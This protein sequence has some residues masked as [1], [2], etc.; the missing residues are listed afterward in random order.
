M[1]CI[2]S[3]RWSALVCLLAVLTGRALAQGVDIDQ[4]FPSFKI[5]DDILAKNPKNAVA[6]R[7]RGTAYYHQKDF[8]NAI[9][10]FTQ[11]I[12]LNPKDTLAYTGRGV[13]HFKNGN[14]GDALDDLKHAVRLNPNSASIYRHLID[15]CF[16]NEDW[17]NVISNATQLIRVN[18]SESAWACETRGEAWQ[19]KSNFDRAI[20]EFDAAIRLNPNWDAP[21]RERASILEKKGDFDGVLADLNELVRL[22]PHNDQNYY[23]RSHIYREKSDWDGIIANWTEAIANNPT[24]T[25]YLYTRARAYQNHNKDFAKAIA[26]YNKIVELEPN[27]PRHYMARGFAYERENLFEMAITNYSE[28]IQLNPTNSDGY[29]GR[30]GAYFHD[31]QY[32]EARKDFD[33]GI[34][35]NPENWAGYTGLAY[36][37]AIC[38]DASFR[39]GREAL[40]MAQKGYDLNQP[41][42]AWIS[43]HCASALA[44][45]YAEV[46]NFDNAIR[47]QKQ[48]LDTVSNAQGWGLAKED[49]EKMKECLALFEQ[50]KPYREPT[51]SQPKP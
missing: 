49:L 18:P 16:F 51:K 44:V 22:D 34:Q 47:Y 8:T 10:D 12:A 36:F 20:K 32:K 23:T 30:A 39:N 11:A 14:G 7:E 43:V 19:Y 38:P 26:D 4:D 40:K 13:S 15:V 37:L 50:H 2:L 25:D 28:L 1:I 5:Y 6:Y 3:K 41:P 35:L 17:D 33:R 29:L 42:E 9:A 24:N 31:G 27:K 48:A 21:H 46:G 45:A